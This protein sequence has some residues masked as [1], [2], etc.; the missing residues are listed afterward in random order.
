M[1]LTDRQVRNAKPGPKPVKLFDGGG[2]F[3]LVT[4]NG[5]KWWA[6]QVQLWGQG[7][8]SLAGLLPQISLKDARN[9]RDEVWKQLAMGVSSR[10]QS[11]GAAGRSGRGG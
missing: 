8:A 4:P 6:L 7:E 1:P 10:R 9:S 2:L 3:L 5:G 11:Q